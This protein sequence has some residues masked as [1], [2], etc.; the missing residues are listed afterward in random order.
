MQNEAL[1]KIRTMRQVGTSIDVARNERVRTTNSLY[2]PEEE[3]AR[4]QSLADRRLEQVLA[5]ERKRFAAQEASVDKSRR[6]M[7][8]SRDKLA[9]IIN[10]NH[11]L[12]ELRHE[13]Q[14]ARWEERDSVLSKIEPSAE[15]KNLHRMELRY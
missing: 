3:V 10:K 4:L 13:L 14:R 2:Q 6:R 1:R 12:T 15:S 7:L 5:K 8:K 11:A 9:A